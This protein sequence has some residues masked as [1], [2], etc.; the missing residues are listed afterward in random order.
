[1]QWSVYLQPTGTAVVAQWVRALTLQ[2]GRLGVR[3]PAATDLSR[4]TGGDSSTAKRMTIGASVTEMT[5]I[6][7]WPVSQ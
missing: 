2:S 7:G 1:M 6:K 3:I 4:K 5:I